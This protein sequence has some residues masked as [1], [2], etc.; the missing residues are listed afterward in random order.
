MSES[1]RWK[2][3]QRQVGDVQRSTGA[4]LTEA[5]VFQE[6]HDRKLNGRVVLDLS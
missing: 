6:M 2:S 3:S 1:R 4:M 5:Q